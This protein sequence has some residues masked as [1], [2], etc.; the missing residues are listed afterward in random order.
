[1]NQK[2]ICFLSKKLPNYMIPSLY[3]NIDKIPLTI[4]GK[5]DYRSLPEPE[6]VKKIDIF[7]HETKLKKKSV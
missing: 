5:L 3:I 1:M 4:N 6:F 7:H 2:L